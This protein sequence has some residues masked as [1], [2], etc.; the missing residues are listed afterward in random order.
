MAIKSRRGLCRYCYSN[1][2]KLVKKR[3]TTW[4]QLEQEGK[5]GPSQGKMACFGG[6]MVKASREFTKV[7][8]G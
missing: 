3:I 5:C 6:K 2:T 4:E 7:N 1:Y 8:D